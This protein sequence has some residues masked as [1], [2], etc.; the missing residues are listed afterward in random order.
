[1]RVIYVFRPILMW[2]AFSFGL[3]TAGTTSAFASIP[4]SANAAAS[5]SPALATSGISFSGRDIPTTSPMAETLV[6]IVTAPGLSSMNPTPS[7]PLKAICVHPAFASDASIYPASARY[8]SS[9][10]LVP[11]SN[12][13]PENCVNLLAIRSICWSVRTRAALYFAS[14]KRASSARALASAARSFDTATFWSEIRCSS[15]WAFERLPPKVISPYMATASKR[16]QAMR[17]AVS[18]G[19]LLPEY[20]NKT[21][22]SKTNATTTA[23]SQK[24]SLREF[25]S[26]SRLSS[27]SLVSLFCSA[28]LSIGFLRVGQN[29]HYTPS[30]RERLAW[31]VAWL[32]FWLLVVVIVATRP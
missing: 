8:S 21:I 3:G 9:L 31:R 30:R 10:A 20:C 4:S 7:E 32:I 11:T 23:R 18:S 6:P 15:A 19:G 2:M 27:A 29:R 16:L 13:T 28:F 12:C 1:M 24:P 26:T 22:A 25:S 5:A 14:A 17:S